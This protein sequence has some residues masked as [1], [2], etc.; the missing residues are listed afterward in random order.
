MGV[1][2]TSKKDE[3][4]FRSVFYDLINRVTNRQYVSKVQI[5]AR[6]NDIRFRP[7]MTRLK[8]VYSEGAYKK[9]MNKV[10]T[11]DASKRPQ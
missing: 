10:R 11:V 6:T 2:F 7:A 4:L 8:S 9:I 1:N 5:L 3:V